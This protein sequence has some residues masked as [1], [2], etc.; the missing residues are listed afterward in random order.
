[1]TLNGVSNDQGFGAQVS[2]GVD[3]ASAYDAFTLLQSDYNIR[4]A[5][6]AGRLETSGR[7]EVFFLRGG[8]QAGGMALN[9]LNWVL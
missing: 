1:L 6:I 9:S 4:V 8:S 5:S 2:V 7:V 3:S